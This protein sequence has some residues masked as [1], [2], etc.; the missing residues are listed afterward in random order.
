MAER[1]VVVEERDELS[2]G[3]ARLRAMLEGSDVEGARSYV[4]ELVSRWPEDAAVRHW[5]R[6]LEPPRMLGTRPPT[7]RSLRAEGEWLREHGRNYPGCWLVLDGNRLVVAT[8][9]LDEAIEVARGD[10]ANDPLYHFQP[11]PA[12]WP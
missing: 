5:D 6:V 2:E 8:P 4:K 12:K 9:S 7:G 11:D 10:G 3:L 1:A